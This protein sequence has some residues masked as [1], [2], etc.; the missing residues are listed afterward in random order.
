MEN[1]NIIFNCALEQYNKKYRNRRHRLLKYT[2]K[3]VEEFDKKYGHYSYD[4]KTKALNFNKFLLKKRKWALIGDTYYEIPKPVRFTWFRN[5]SAGV[6]AITCLV[7]AGVVATAIAVPSVLLNN[8]APTI[9]VEGADIDQ[10]A[11]HIE[12]HKD[13]YIVLKEQGSR[14]IIDVTEVKVGGNAITKETDWTYNDKKVDIKAHAMTSTK[15]EIKVESKVET[16]KEKFIRLA[17]VYESNFQKSTN[18]YDEDDVS[19]VKLT[20]TS[21]TVTDV[22]YTGSG[23]SRECY[24]ETSDSYKIY[25]KASF[26]GTLDFLQEESAEAV[27]TFN[28]DYID[29]SNPTDSYLKKLTI[30]KHGYITDI[31]DTALKGQYSLTLAGNPHAPRHVTNLIYEGYSED[32]VDSISNNINFNGTPKEKIK[33]GTTTLTVNCTVLLRNGNTGW[34]KIYSDKPHSTHLAT[35]NICSQTGKYVN[36]N[37]TLD[38]STIDLNNYDKL[39]VVAGVN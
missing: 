34:L 9:T 39:Y 16:A 19:N 33:A 29:Y 25:I 11:S 38:L 6:Q 20:G 36:F 8:S 24:L 26:D 35:S 28:N 18:V 17:G 32:S 21:K 31:Y 5:L 22:V 27:Y 23:A 7:G 37:F 30:T 14:S 2:K 13:S 15:I 4:G 3:D 12:L 10:S 1:K